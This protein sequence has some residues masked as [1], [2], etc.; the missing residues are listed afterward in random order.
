MTPA[1]PAR[2]VRRR[3]AR[4]GMTLIEAMISIAILAIVTT[5]VY[6]GLSQTMRNKRRVEEQLDHSHVI[7]V[8]MER[9][10]RELQQAFVSVH[11]NPSAQLQ[12]MLT[13]FHG[14]REGRASRIDFTSF[15][16]RRLFRDAHESDQNELSYFV[17]RHP[18]DHDKR[19]LVRREANRIDDQPGRGGQLMILVEDVHDFKLEYLDAQ[20]L[21]WLDSWD[22]GPNGDHPNLLPAQVRVTLEVDHPFRR[23][24]TERFVT[25]VSIPITYAINHAAYAP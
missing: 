20:S 18:D 25:R 21:D 15:S 16:H 5:V 9:I 11:V 19:V 6:G 12:A 23:G 8:T 3:G 24:R 7:R 13:T 10:V 2:R 1:S 17:A 4:D 14:Y 22:G